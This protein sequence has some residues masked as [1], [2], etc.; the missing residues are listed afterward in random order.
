ML[1]VQRQDSA[2]MLSRQQPAR[3]REG[4]PRPNDEQLE[5][6]RQYLRTHAAITR[7]LDAELARDHGLG[8]SEY[9]VLLFLSRAPGNQMRLIRLAE[10]SLVTRSGMTRLI[11]RLE[12][13]GLVERLRCPSDRRGFNAHMTDAGRDLARA[14]GKTHLA[15][16]KRL[17]VDPLAEELGPLGTS[18]ERL[19]DTPDDALPPCEPGD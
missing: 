1:T 2:A 14:A 3:P 7:Q 9:E 19:P 5:V 13:R 4:Q 12:E 16:V 17:F 8:L 10:E 6:W 11:T 15:G 18:L